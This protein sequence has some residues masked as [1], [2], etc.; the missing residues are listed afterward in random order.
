MLQ[1]PDVQSSAFWGHIGDQVVRRNFSVVTLVKRK[2]TSKQDDALQKQKQEADQDSRLRPV[3]S[4]IR[5]RE[6]F[7]LI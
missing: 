2:R 4:Y 3:M 1:D 5:E 7:S 6:A